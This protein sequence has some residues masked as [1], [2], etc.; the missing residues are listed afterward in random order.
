MT[1][2]ESNQLGYFFLCPVHSLS[3]QKLSACK[4]LSCFVQK[5]RCSLKSTCNIES[6]AVI[7]WFKA[8]SETFQKNKTKTKI[9][10]TKSKIRATQ[11]SN[12]RIQTS[13][14]RAFL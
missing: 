13:S 1:Y 14:Y 9:N 3:L 11:K 6:E 4:K 10:M 7:D 8:E 5:E 2:T 12:L